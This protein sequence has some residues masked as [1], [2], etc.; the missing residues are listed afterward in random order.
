LTEALIVAL[1]DLKQAL[2]LHLD[3]K[4]V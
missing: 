4:S 1:T 3:Q 2:Q